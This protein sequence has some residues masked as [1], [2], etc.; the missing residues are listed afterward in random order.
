LADRLVTLSGQIDVH[1]V[2][3]VNDR[4]EF[5]GQAQS[6]PG[7]TKAREYGFSFLMFAIATIVNIFLEN[8]QVNQPTGL[9]YLLTVVLSGAF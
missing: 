7:Q 5:P 2:R 6:I 1:M 4:Q 9:M 3:I 8:G